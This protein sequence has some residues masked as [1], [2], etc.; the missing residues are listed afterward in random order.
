MQREYDVES[1]AAEYLQ[2]ADALPHRALGESALLE[3][4]PSVPLRVLDLGCGDGRLLALILEARPRSTGVAIDVS[5][6]MLQR[7]KMRFAGHPE[8]RVIEH[9]LSQPLAENLVDFDA[10]VS[11]FA[12]H[13]LSDPRKLELYKEV[14]ATL[15]PGGV[16]CNLEHVSPA[17][18]ALN[19]RFLSA[20][21][22]EEDAT[23]ILL[24]IN[25][26]LTWLRE[27]GFEEVDCDWKWL[28]LALLAGA[29]PT[30][31]E[32]AAKSR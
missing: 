32:A 9:D 23:N 18:P 3:R 2:I 21:E 8:V 4:L 27:L 1:K 22:V 30:G 12:I 16:F 25:T 13:H 6:P 28:E 15:R 10:V 24:D 29:K 26:Q 11:S 14:Y 5:P 17:S 7:A 19:A 31:G 20:L